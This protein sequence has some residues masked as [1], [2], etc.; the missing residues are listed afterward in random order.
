ME[1]RVSSLVPMSEDH[2]GQ[3]SGVN[4]GRMQIILYF[5]LFAS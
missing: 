2:G 3:K 4:M 5:G 1:E